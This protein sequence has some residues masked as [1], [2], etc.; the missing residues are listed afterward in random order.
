MW[1]APSASAEQSTARCAILLL[2]GAVMVPP[3]PPEVC[4]IVTNITIL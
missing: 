3:M 2:G 1:E 4:F